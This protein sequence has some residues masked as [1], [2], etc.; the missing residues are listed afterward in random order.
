MLRP[1]NSW[2]RLTTLVALI[3]LSLAAGCASNPDAGL[4][5][6]QDLPSVDAVA[7]VKPGPP[8]ALDPEAHRARIE[9]IDAG[10][11]S[12][13]PRAVGDVCSLINE[14]GFHVGTSGGLPGQNAM[15]A[16]HRFE[17]NCMS[18]AVG[19]RGVDELITEWAALRDKLFRPA[20]WFR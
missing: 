7:K 17:P 9:A 2:T 15:K 11:R 5:E 4:I 13:D 10:L 3:A 8:G 16:L 20:P 14:L 1:L 12:S 18:V 19:D 6:E